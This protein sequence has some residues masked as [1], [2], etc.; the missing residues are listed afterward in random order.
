MKN[1]TF[2]A[3][4]DLIAKARER[5]SLEHR[6]LNLVFREWLTHYAL[7]DAADYDAVM[8]S[9]SDIHAPRPFTRAEL[10]ER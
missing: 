9:L 10:N 3:E 7:G 1:I 6:N 5:A 4:A 8:E 2:S